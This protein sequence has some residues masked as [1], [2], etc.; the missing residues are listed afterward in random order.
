M[1]KITSNNAKRYN[2]SVPTLH[3][4]RD[5]ATRT[6]DSEPGRFYRQ[7]MGKEWDGE[8][9]SYNLARRRFCELQ[10]RRQRTQ[11]NSLASDAAFTA[12]SVPTAASQ[13][14]PQR[15]H[16]RAREQVQHL[17]EQGR[18]KLRKIA[19]AETASFTAALASIEQQ[20]LPPPVTLLKP[21]PS[22]PLQAMM[23]ASTPRLASAHGQ[24]GGGGGP[25][26]EGGLPLH[27]S[28]HGQEGSGGGALTEGGLPLHASA[29]GQ[30]G[31]GGGSLTEGGQQ[32]LPSTSQPPPA[33][34]PSPPPSPPTLSPHPCPPPSSRSVV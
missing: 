31:G 22:P 18:E 17:L 20:P 23:V 25:L 33:P 4:Y 10:N 26:T 7:V 1:T 2:A 29:H 21:L 24:D 15:K 12:A 8:N 32:P 3:K 13:S 9:H 5:K 30:E 6:T 19:S 11:V 34:P 14:L 27:A 28:A 16:A